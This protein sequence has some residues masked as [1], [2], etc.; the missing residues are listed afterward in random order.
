MTSDKTAK[1]RVSS[2]AVAVLLGAIG[3][4]LANA[5]S[6]GV[7]GPQGFALGAFGPLALLIGVAALRRPSQHP[8]DASAGVDRPAD[9]RV[10][11]PKRRDG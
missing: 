2:V 11:E 7:S 6:G 5:G 8:E 9:T 4:S 1:A 10:N 3:M